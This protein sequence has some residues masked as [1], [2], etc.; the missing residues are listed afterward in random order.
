LNKW[1]KVTIKG[2]KNEEVKMIVEKKY[3]VV[4]DF[5]S[6]IIETFERIKG[7]IK[8]EENEEIVKSLNFGRTFSLRDLIKWCDRI[9][10][11]HGNRILNSNYLL[12]EIKDSIFLEAVDVFCGMISKENFLKAIEKIIAKSLEITPEK[13]EYY[14]DNYKPSIEE[15]SNNVKIGRIVF[16]INNTNEEIFNK[17]KKERNFAYTKYSLRLLEKISACV[18]MNEPV[19]LTGKLKNKIR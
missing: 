6:K 19:L 1:R 12:T 5:T 16:S 8:D 7:D 13:V 11:I 15:K 2:L 18:E 4:K 17:K 3:P 9:Q 10:Q 14:K